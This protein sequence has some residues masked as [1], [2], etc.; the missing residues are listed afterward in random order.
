MKKTKLWM[1]VTF[2]VVVLFAML[3]I[4]ACPQGVNSDNGGGGLKALSILRA[5]L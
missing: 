4:V 5:G 2:S 3:A 1:S